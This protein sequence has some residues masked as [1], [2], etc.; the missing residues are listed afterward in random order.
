MARVRQL[1]ERHQSSG[2]VEPFVLGQSVVVGAR[3]VGSVRF[4]FSAKEIE[5]RENLGTPQT[6][7]EALR[8]LH[9]RFFG[10]SWLFSTCQIRFQSVP[11]CQFSMPDCISRPTCGRLPALARGCRLERTR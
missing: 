2:D 6:P 8:P 7:A 4:A 10:S 3:A 11:G 9:S 1:C 5:E